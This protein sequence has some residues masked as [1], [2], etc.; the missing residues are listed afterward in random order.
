M[1]P[2][3]SAC[4]LLLVMSWL[5]AAGAEPQPRTLEGQ[6]WVGGLALS[7][8]GKT[9]ASGGKD[10]TARLWEVAT[11]KAGLV[12]K[13]HTDAVCAVAFDSAGKLLATGSHDGTARLW[14]VQTG[15]ERA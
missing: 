1:S 2:R 10:R 11:G 3:R 8:D 15:K 13:G 5:P 6:G 14:D 7:P 9:L 12:F 4:L